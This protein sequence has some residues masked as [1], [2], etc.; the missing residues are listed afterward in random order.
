MLQNASFSHPAKYVHKHIA[1]VFNVRIL[2]IQN[3]YDQ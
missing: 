2:Q 3:L 1:T